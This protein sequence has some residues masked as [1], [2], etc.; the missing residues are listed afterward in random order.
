MATQTSS[1]KTLR[2][3]LKPSKKATGDVGMELEVEAMVRLPVLESDYWRTKD[4][5]SLRFVA[6]EYV[7]NGPQKIENVEKAL[8]ELIKA[9]DDPSFAILK[10]SPRTSFHVHVNASD[11]THLQIANALIAYWFFEPALVRFVDK[12]RKGNC[13][14]LTL[15]DSED[16]LTALDNIV[17]NRD[18]LFYVSNE[19]RYASQN[20]ASLSTFGSIENRMCDG[21]IDKTKM[22][23]WVRTLY[24]ISV[25]SEE[26]ETPIDMLNYFYRQEKRKLV[27]DFLVGTCRSKVLE[28]D[29]VSELESN[30][31]ILHRVITKTRWKSWS[32]SINTDDNILP[33]PKVRR[34]LPEFVAL[35]DAWSPVNQIPNGIQSRGTLEEIRTRNRT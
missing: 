19:M 32:N 9:L 12:S 8:D 7:S 4:D 35:D 11:K 22:L 3:F 26:F 23:D 33:A 15:Q 5:G 28:G 13:F 17:R 10:K 1:A 6:R 34:T 14:C 20:M 31:V 18:R 2:D 30:E 29:Y 24:N 25:K 21:A 27:N 16:P